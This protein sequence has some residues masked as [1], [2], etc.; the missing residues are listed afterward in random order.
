MPNADPFDPDRWQTG[1]DQVPTPEPK[2]TRKFRPRRA[3]RFLKGPVPWSWLLRAMQ[4]PGK[5]L[6][7]GLMLWFQCGLTG[8]WTIHFC[9]PRAAAEG[10]PI[11]TARRAMRELERAGLV[12]IR[13]RPGRGLEVTLLE[14]DTQ[15]TG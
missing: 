10:I 8:R 13:R 2:P 3:D 11:T 6:A 1:S 5:A 4:L 9:L 14:T 12:T 15:P 7:L